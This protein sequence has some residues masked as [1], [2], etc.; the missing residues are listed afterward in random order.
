MLGSCPDLVF[1]INK[2]AQYSA[3]PTQKHWKGIKRILRFVKAT[4]NAKLTLGNKDTT[5]E[6][7]PTVF[8]HQ[9]NPTEVTNPKVTHSMVVG[10]FDAAYMDNT[11]DRHSTMGYMFFVAGSS[12]SWISKKQTVVALSTTEAEYLAGTEPTKEVVWIQ[13]FLQA[14]GIPS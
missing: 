10:Y 12:V 8:G 3:N 5:G 11:R 1:S 2:L 7:K 6:I 9:Q 4:I 13:A 14:I